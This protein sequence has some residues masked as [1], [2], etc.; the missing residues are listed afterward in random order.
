MAKQSRT[1]YIQAEMIGTSVMVAAAEATRS[2]AI[3][4]LGGPEV[5]IIA[6]HES[7]AW[8][9]SKWV[10]VAWRRQ[11]DDSIASDAPR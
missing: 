3:R 1:I 4:E 5:E 11:W 10:G 6:C 7:P 2:E 8:N 9:G